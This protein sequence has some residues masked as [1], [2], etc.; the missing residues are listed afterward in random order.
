MFLYDQNSGVTLILGVDRETLTIANTSRSGLSSPISL[1]I[2]RQIIY[3]VLVPD[4]TIVRIV[5]V[6]C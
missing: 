6:T 2:G 3:M 4:P 1:G 5:V